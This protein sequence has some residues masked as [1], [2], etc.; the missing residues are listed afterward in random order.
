MPVPRVQKDGLPLSFHHCTFPSFQHLRRRIKFIFDLVP[1]NAL[2][3]QPITVSRKPTSTHLLAELPDELPGLPKGIGGSQELDG[4]DR[5]S[6]ARGQVGRGDRYR[7]PH[8]KPQRDL[9]KK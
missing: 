2:L 3:Q 9:R 5:R 4:Q 8:C 1:I 6:D 7:G